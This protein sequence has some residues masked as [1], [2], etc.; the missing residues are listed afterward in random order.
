M[1]FACEFDSSGGNM[2]I[3]DDN[4]EMV[5]KSYIGT[6]GVEIKNDVLY[7]SVEY[8]KLLEETLDENDIV[9]GSST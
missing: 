3:Y 5:Y 7:Y 6:E 8:G 9:F 4:G 1:I 2:Y